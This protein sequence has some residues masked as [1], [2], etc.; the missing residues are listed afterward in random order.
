MQILSQLSR[1]EGFCAYEGHQLISAA[2]GSGYEVY[3]LS[4][5]RS[6]LP[7]IQEKSTLTHRAALELGLDLCA[8]LAACRRAGYLYVDLRPDNL[9]F[10]QKQG[11][12]IGDLGFLPLHSLAFAGLPR[13][14]RSVY[15][16]PEMGDDLAPLNNTLDIY[17]LGLLL[18]GLFN[19]GSLPKDS[20]AAPSYADYELTDI[21][22]KACHK[23]P[24]RRWQDP[25]QFAQ[26]LIG[27][28]Q[29][30]EVRDTP[31]SPIPHTDSFVPEEA[32]FLPPVTDEELQKEIA[33]LP[34]NE[35]RL[36]EAMSAETDD[37]LELLAQA[38]ALLRTQEPEPEAPRDVPRPV[39]KPTPTPDL[40]SKPLA[41]APEAIDCP[42]ERRPFPWKKL[43][44]VLAA[45]LL[46]LLGI[47][48]KSYYDNVYI[49]HISQLQILQQGFIC[50]KRILPINGI[51][52]TDLGRRPVC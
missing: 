5:Y 37:T 42:R 17:A 40:Q 18:T 46:V 28:M 45:V 2:D 6:S 7:Y 21:L 27:Y 26:A 33:L 22:S 24:D 15:T 14:Y 19:G 49:Q 10:D 32:D 9:F 1:Q 38:N 13:Q 29:R 12:Q 30:N 3:L 43:L 8:A 4:R 16:A 39:E 20:K 25:T 51:G 23:N 50:K 48:A 34:E 44:G 52:H 36:M 35:V 47:R 41:A 31:L 11:W